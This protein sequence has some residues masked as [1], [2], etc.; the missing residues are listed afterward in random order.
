[1]IVLGIET[2]AHT[3]GVAIIKD[4][5]VLSNVKDMYTTESGGMIPFELGE[6]HLTVCDTIL[7]NALKIAGVKI[8]EVDLIAVSNAP[9]IG[10]ALRIGFNFAKSL[11]LIFHKP[12]VG[13][14]HCIA[15]LEIGKLLTPVK[16]PVLLYAS[17]ANTQ[18]IAYEGQKYRVFGETLDT[19]I[20]NFLDSFGRELGLGFPAGPKIEQLALKG[21]KFIALPYVVKGMD[22]SFSGLFTKLKGLMKTESYEDLCYSVQE[23][24]F[25]MLV[26][27]SE[28]ALAHTGKKELVLGGGVACNKRLQEMCRIMCEERGAKAY[29]IP[30]EFYVDNAAMIAYTGLLKYKAEKIDEVLSLRIKPY[31][32]TDEVN[33]TWV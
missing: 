14:N 12:L 25:A 2:T 28:R 20:G 15:H 11:A 6:H 19:G 9:G 26:E 27:V 29:F 31:E 8:S 23:T 1:M 3:F 5:K 18:I 13:V 7:N 33:V 4:K 32:R 10:N 21:E 17:G 24:V 16:D 22:V 30:N